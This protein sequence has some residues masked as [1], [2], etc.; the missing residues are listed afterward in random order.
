MK[1]YRKLLLT[2]FSFGL[3]ITAAQNASAQALID[4][5]MGIA[6]S[7]DS[8]LKIFKAPPP[9][10]MILNELHRQ[11]FTDVSDLAPTPIGSPMKATATSP[12]GTPVDLIIDPMTG[13]LLSTTPR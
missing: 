13:K 11:G 10:S 1:K 6:A 8:D 4:S 7:S 2:A 9:T 5:A 12:A 3:T